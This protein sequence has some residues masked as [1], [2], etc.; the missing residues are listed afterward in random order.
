MQFLT[1]AALITRNKV[2]R[3]PFLKKCLV[4]KFF[5]FFSR[6]IANQQISCQLN[7]LEKFQKKKSKYIK[8]QNFPYK[9]QNCFQAQLLEILWTKVP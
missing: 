7:I 8:S 3:K 2:L 4:R 5:R 1:L 9:F 6:S